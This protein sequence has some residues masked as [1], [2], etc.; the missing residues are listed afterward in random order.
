MGESTK[1]PP[2]IGDVATGQDPEADGRWS[3]LWTRWQYA[4]QDDE[5]ECTAVQAG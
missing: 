2:R 4:S 1:K 5:P 3:I